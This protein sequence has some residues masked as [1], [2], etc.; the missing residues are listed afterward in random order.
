MVRFFVHQFSYSF[1]IIFPG[2][3]ELFEQRNSDL[4]VETLPVR[5]PRGAAVSE[6]DGIAGQGSNVAAICHYCRGRSDH[7]VAEQAGL[8]GI[9][10]SQL[11][12][13]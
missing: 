13:A 12:N 10:L 5:P 3:P 7:G 8:T 1:F 11:L 2:W 4:Q 6:V 9:N